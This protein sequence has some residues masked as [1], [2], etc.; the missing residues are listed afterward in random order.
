M[1]LYKISQ[2]KNVGYDT[3][4]SAVVAA[5][6]EEAARLINPS[7]YSDSDYWA[8][9]VWV[10]DLNNVSVQFIGVAAVG[11]A[12]GVIVASFNAG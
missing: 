7:G 10:K 5:E 6:T 1:N 9:S 8:E 11:I 4:D 3:Y 12:S 2:S